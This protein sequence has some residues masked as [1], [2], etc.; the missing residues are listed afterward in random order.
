MK[1]FSRDFRHYLFFARFNGTWR[2]RTSSRKTSRTGSS[3]CQCVN[4][5]EWKTNDEENCISKAEKIKNYAMRFLQG[6][7]T[8]SRSS[9]RGSVMIFQTTLEKKIHLTQLCEEAFCQ[10][11]VVTGNHYKIRLNA[12]VFS[13]KMCL[14][15]R[16]LPR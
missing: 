3:S 15:P 7:W 11:L 4:D 16:I 2:Q 8:F 13:D 14:R 10:H 5:I 6:H 1:N 9:V 12:Q